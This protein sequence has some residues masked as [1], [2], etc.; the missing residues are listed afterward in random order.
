MICIRRESNARDK[1]GEYSPRD[2]WQ[3]IDGLIRRA[4]HPGKYQEQQQQP[5]KKTDENDTEVDGFLNDNNPEYVCQ[6]LKNKLHVYANHIKELKDRMDKWQ[7]IKVGHQYRAKKDTLG[8]RVIHITQSQDKLPHVS[9][10]LLFLSVAVVAHTECLSGA[11][12]DFRE[13][14]APSSKCL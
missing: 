2:D 3:D 14:N 8:R 11:N 9:L 10:L 4:L 5:Q 12:Q 7:A 1:D 13:S 6:M